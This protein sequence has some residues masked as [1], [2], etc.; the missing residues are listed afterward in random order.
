M[1]P[2]MTPEEVALAR[3]AFNSN[4]GPGTLESIVRAGHEKTRNVV[5]DVASL[6]RTYAELN[7]PGV[8]KF[9]DFLIS[10]DELQEIGS[11]S[12]DL[13]GVAHKPATVERMMSLQELYIGNPR[14]GLTPL[15]WLTHLSRGLSG[16]PPAQI[17]IFDRFCGELIDFASLGR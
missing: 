8:V 4:E 1:S 2:K 15:Q 9:I 12:I 13:A 6:K 7:C 3:P 11:G 17:K 5:V 16:V 14:L 10:D